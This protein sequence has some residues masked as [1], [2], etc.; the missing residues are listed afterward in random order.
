MNKEASIKEILENGVENIY[1]NKD[2]LE[3]VLKSGKKIRLY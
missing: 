2:V 3:K 1:P